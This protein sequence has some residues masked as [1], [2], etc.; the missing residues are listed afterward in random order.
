MSVIS[1]LTFPGNPHIR[2]NGREGLPSY[3]KTLNGMRN[4]NQ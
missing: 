1:G 4:T 2:N 3:R